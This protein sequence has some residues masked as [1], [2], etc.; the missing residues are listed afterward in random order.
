MTNLEREQRLREEIGAA[1]DAEE[2]RLLLPRM[3]A[4]F[5]ESDDD[6]DQRQGGARF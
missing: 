6:G 1:Q 5:I 3:Y 2:L 4:L